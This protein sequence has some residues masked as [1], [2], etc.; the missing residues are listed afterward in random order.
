MKP[1]ARR[2]SRWFA[3]LFVAALLPACAVNRLPPS[4][5][6]GTPILAVISWNLHEDQGD[7]SRLLGDLNLG[8]TPYVLLLQEAVD[9]QRRHD[10][11]A[12]TRQAERGLLGNAIVSTLPVEDARQVELPQARQRR[13]AAVATVRVGATPIVVVST[14][15]ENRVSWWRGGLFS[16]GARARQTRALLTALPA[17]APVVLGGD[18]NTWL[19][20]R[21]PAWRLL[22]ERFPG[23]PRGARQAPTFRERLTLDH[24]F[25]DL[26][27]GW[28]METRVIAGRYGSDHHPVLGLIFR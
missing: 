27:A 6:P 4:S 28:S 8:A 15:L 11:F 19:G 5:L 3:A 22:L 24:L 13:T 17:D 18:L 23:T 2:R 1:A 20:P 9:G 16:D 10:V 26:P 12:S 7:L 14:H 21:E 25:A